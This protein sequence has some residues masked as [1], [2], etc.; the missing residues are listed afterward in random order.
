MFYPLIIYTHL[1]VG[2]NDYYL[3]DGDVALSLVRICSLIQE[4][5]ICRKAKQTYTV[6]MEC[7]PETVHVFRLPFS[8]GQTYVL[9][10]YVSVLV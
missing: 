9:L 2:F 6:A 8:G 10:V 5:R 4:V 3:H 7:E 1:K